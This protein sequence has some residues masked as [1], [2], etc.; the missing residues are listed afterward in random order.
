MARGGNCPA[1]RERNAALPPLSAYPKASGPKEAPSHSGCAEPGEAQRQAK[2]CRASGKTVPPQK[3]RAPGPFLP[4]CARR[5]RGCLVPAAWPPLQASSSSPAKVSRRRSRRAMPTPEEPG[6]S[7]AQGGS[8]AGGGKGRSRWRRSG[9][10]GAPP[11]L[12]IA[13]LAEGVGGAPR[14]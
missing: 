8:P 11:P 1:K 4:L 3:A 13:R 2:L 6:R 9:L 7:A 14:S 5:K 12:R 10:L